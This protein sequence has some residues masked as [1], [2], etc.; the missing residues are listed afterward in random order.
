MSEL[1]DKSEI[2]KRL[3]AACSNMGSLACISCVIP[4]IVKDTL[5]VDAE[6]VKQG[7][8]INKVFFTVSALRCTNEVR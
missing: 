2:S 3:C 4:H 8:W 6:P 1:I 7:Q 5:T